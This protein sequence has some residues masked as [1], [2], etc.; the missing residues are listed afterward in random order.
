MRLLILLILGF[1]FSFGQNLS[2]SPGAISE[3]NISLNYYNTEYIFIQNT[4]TEILNLE[5]E[6]VEEDIPSDWASSGC[7]NVIC[8]IS[9]PENGPLGDLNPGE[10]AYLSI[11]LSVNDSPGDALIR[12]RIFDKN[13]PQINDTITFIYK[14][15]SDTLY[16]TPQPWAKINFYQNVLTVF[17]KG[18]NSKTELKVF[19]LGGKLIAQQEIQTITSLSF[20][21]FTNGIYIIMVENESGQQIIQKVF[22]GS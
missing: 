10:E 21:N 15:E 14:A 19:D 11:N 16:A 17:L 22:K 8:Y 3:N 7:T 12:F 20:Q 6:L 18:G 2:F 4:T 13:M 1:H 5:F 9:V